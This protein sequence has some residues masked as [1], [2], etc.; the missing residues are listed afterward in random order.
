MAGT[1]SDLPTLHPIYP[2]PFSENFFEKG[3][4]QLAL[5][6]HSVCVLRV[7]I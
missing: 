1:V 3:S 6:R 5:R 4:E 2:S 7:S